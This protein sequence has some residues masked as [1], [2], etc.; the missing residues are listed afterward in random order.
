MTPLP[1]GLNYYMNFLEQSSKVLLRRE[2]YQKVNCPE[3]AL[4]IRMAGRGGTKV[5]WTATR[6]EL[7]Q[8]L[9]DAAKSLGARL[10]PRLLVAVRP[11]AEAYF[12]TTARGGE[13]RVV[14]NDALSDAPLDVLEAL[15]EIIVARA[16]GAA[17]PRMVGKPF[18]DYVETE[19]LKERMQAN[20]MARQRSFDPEL[21]GRAWDLLQLFDAVN[22]D[23]FDNSIPH[24]L[25]GWT[26][27]PLTYRWGWYS[28]MVRPHGLIV[29]NRL[30]DDPQVPRFVLEGTMYHEM[31]H[32]QVDPVVVNGRRIV[33]TSTFRALDSKF[34]RHEDLRPEYRKVLRR[35]GRK[36]GAVRRTR[37]HRGWR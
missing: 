18:W 27:R 17:R 4:L 16:S 14:I 11:L 22:K 29:I 13:L 5:Q 23:Y 31:L 6:E 8:M 25:L 19:E 2:P 10:P 21:Q 1:I 12:R 9:R 33:H 28:S 3:I 37:S 34:D 15:C 7:E 30:L 26:R 20:Y 35:Y 32:M 36:V 24:P